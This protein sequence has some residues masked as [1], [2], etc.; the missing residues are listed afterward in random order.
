MRKRQITSCEWLVVNKKAHTKSLL[1][2]ILETENF[3]EIVDLV[4]ELA[5]WLEISLEET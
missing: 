1:L 5:D 3:E 2:A 4:F